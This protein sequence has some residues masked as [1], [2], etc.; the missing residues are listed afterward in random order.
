MAFVR[1]HSLHRY[2]VDA[3]PCVPDTVNRHRATVMQSIVYEQDA[4]LKHLRC[5]LRNSDFFCDPTIA[6][7]EG[8]LGTRPK[9]WWW[10]WRVLDRVTRAGVWMGP[11]NLWV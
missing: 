10:G 9:A 11:R 7:T 6:W 2:L 3:S 5:P 8:E 1:A 4:A